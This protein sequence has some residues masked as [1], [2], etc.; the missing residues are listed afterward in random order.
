M[1]RVEA[2]HSRE[3]RGLAGSGRWEGTW[4]E[5]SGAPMRCQGCWGSSPQPSAQCI[6]PCLLSRIP[7]RLPPAPGSRQHRLDTDCPAIV[8]LQLWCQL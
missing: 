7:G 1:G 4:E 2:R 3:D 8:G 5:G 6:N